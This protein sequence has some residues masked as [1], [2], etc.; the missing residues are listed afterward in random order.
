MPRS[1]LLGSGW[2]GA[3]LVAVTYVDFLIFAQFG[4]LQRLAELGIAS[5]HLK[6]VMAAMALGGV[7]FSLL[8]PRLCAWGRPSTRLRAGLL[9]SAAAAFFSL[10]PLGFA[11]ALLTAMLAGAGLGILTVTLV[12]HLRQ[13]A[14][15]RNPLLAVGLGTG[16]GYLAC[17]FPPLFNAAPGIQALAAGLL[18]LAAMAIPLAPAPAAAERQPKMD[19]GGT[20]FLAVLAAFTALVWLDS[21]AFFIIQN[22]PQ[23]KA[24]TWHGT[25]H[26]WIDGAIHCAA[27]VGSA[28]L[29]G[30]RGI[31]T[32]LAAAFAFLGAACLLL[33]H[34]ASILLA[35]GL[36]PAGVSL[37]SVALVAYPSL[38][39][40]GGSAE[41]RGRRAGW[42]YAVAGWMGSGLGIG[43]GQN[44]GRVPPLFVLAA[45]VAILG[46]QLCEVLRGRRRE[47]AV[48]GGVA[49]AALAWSLLARPRS[50]P[51]LT[52]I[53]K[54]REVYIAEGCMHCHSQYV[55]P[56]SPDELMWGPVEPLAKIRREDPPLIGNRR[57]GPDLTEVGARRS[58]LWLKAHLEDPAEVS[59]ASIMPSYA[60]LFQDQR[61][62]DLVAYL[63]SLRAPDG[64][65]HL[66]EE[67]AWRPSA[68]A[69]A[70][71]SASDGAQLFR[72]YCATCHDAGG[73]TRLRWQ[74]EFQRLPAE[75][76]QG[77]YFDLPAR[78]P[79]PQ[80]Q[81]DLARMTKF[82]IPGTDMS[83]H[84]Y[85]PDP[86]IASIS[87][88]LSQTIAQ[89][90]PN[91]NLFRIIQEKTR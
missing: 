6:A 80:L 60:F 85:L 43:M 78:L 41:E 68:E 26:L 7:S 8:T 36:Y 12:T 13:W 65:A 17:N 29:L 21:A 24:G 64:T 22:T 2:R 40:R 51:P 61:G 82:G 73:R 77:P 33:H 15:A 87:L 89:S 75:F 10:L 56:G 91:R 9:F 45:G 50:A 11:T 27:A 39:I 52:A 72:R 4:F 70:R 42:L 32:V 59:G 30:R 49:L 58:A 37:Y 88:W 28:W 54:G 86:Q 47:L 25:A 23:L 18:C 79:L 84:E 53:E 31:F 57:Q 55:R 3:A 35:S 90:N 20:A 67:Q 16:L 14:G 74:A 48:V 76:P 19:A 66:R 44:L 5:D 62:N 81:I 83:G 1:K 71:A 38:L 46:P 34:P 69:E 63:G